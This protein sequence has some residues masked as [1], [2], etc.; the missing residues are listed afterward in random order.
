MFD[1]NHYVPILKG[2]AAEYLSLQ[3]LHSDIKSLLTP[4][5]EIPPIPWDF[6]NE[7]P[8]RTI[9]DHVANIASKIQSS[10]SEGRPLFLDLSMIAEEETMKDG[11]TPLSYVLDQARQLN[12]RL[13]PVFRL[14]SSRRTIESLAQA[15]S[16]DG[17]GACLRVLGEDFDDED[18]QREI[19]HLISQLGLDYSQTD[20]ILDFG[21][22]TEEHVQNLVRSVRVIAQIIPNLEDWRTFTFAGSAF[23]INLARFAA[24]KVSKISRSELE[25]WESLV[26]NP[27]RIKRLP[28]FAD[29]AIAHPSLEEI[30]PRV[31]RMSAN[32]RYT[33]DRYWLILRGRDVRRYG[34]EQ[35]HALCHTLT[36][37]AE[38]SGPSYSWGDVRIEKCAKKEVGPGN[39]T[40]WRQIG[41]THHLTLVAQQIAR[42]PVL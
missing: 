16:K 25:I 9:D 42:Q 28:S 29:Y 13:I 23:P 30:D 38:Y 26:S 35:F 32:L 41:T 7:K 14:D 39:A 21:E 40:T 18:Q 20:L 27:S 17:L 8:S 33:T 36:L 34:Y 11:R 12:I 31:M 22:V 5:I 4:L 37:H 1:F 3:M 6:E 24:G 10:W 15:V 19:G 2:K